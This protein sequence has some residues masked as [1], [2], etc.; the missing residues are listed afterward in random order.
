MIYCF[1]ALLTCNIA[2]CSNYRLSSTII[3]RWSQKYD[4]CFIL[5]YNSNMKEKYI[6]NIKPHRKNAIQ[7]KCVNAAL[8]NC[9]IFMVHVYG[10]E[11]MKKYDTKL[12]P[13]QTIKDASVLSLVSIS[14]MWK[15]CRQANNSEYGRLILTFI[16][17]DGYSCLSLPQKFA[18]LEQGFGCLI[19]L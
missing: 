3:F 9:T 11:Q 8:K 5:S 16:A 2:F 1:F 7:S 12:P 18:L 14:K 6:T 19:Y 4:I 13:F 17:S 10:I 15:L